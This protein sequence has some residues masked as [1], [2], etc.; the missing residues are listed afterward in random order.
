MKDQIEHSGIVESIEGGYIRVRITQSSACAGCTA[1]SLCQSTESKD[2]IVEVEAP[3]INPGHAKGR[4]NL[5]DGSSQLAGGA[6]AR[7]QKS[8]QDISVGDSVIVY[9]SGEMGR[10]AV[11]LAFVVPLILMVGMIAT[12]IKAMEL[13][14]PASV[15]L[16]F[17]VL[18][19]YYFVLWTQRTRIQKKFV[20]RIKN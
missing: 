5:S 15:G 12:G 14:E 7:Q 18:A 1:R 17:L 11:V 9:G 8:L 6:D 19:I 20:W 16:A 13:S 4:E 3:S 2:K 10:T